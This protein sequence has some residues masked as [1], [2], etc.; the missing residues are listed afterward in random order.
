MSIGIAIRKEAAAKHDIYIQ[1]FNLEERVSF[2]LKCP[3][4]DVVYV[5]YCEPGLKEDSARKDFTDEIWN[6]H[7]RHGEVIAIGGEAVA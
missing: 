5:V 3:D 1:K 2:E 4:C 7:P 6:G